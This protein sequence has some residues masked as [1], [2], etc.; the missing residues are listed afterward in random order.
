MSSIPGLSFVL[1][2]NLEASLKFK[3]DKEHGIKCVQPE[4][5]DLPE[6]KFLRTYKI[7]DGAAAWWF[8]DEIRQRNFVDWLDSTAPNPCDA[9]ADGIGPEGVDDEIKAICFGNNN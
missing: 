3:D 4:I 9:F 7:I 8:N 2:T 1:A 5:K 6:G